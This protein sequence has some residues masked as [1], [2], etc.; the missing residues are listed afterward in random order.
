MTQ[1]VER[2]ENCDGTGMV[3]YATPHYA[4]TAKCPDCDG[5]GE[6]VAE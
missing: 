4:G 6:V 1:K 3:G 2:C 5:T